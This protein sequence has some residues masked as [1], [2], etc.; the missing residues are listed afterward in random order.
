MRNSQKFLVLAVSSIAA[1]GS[2]GYIMIGNYAVP[3]WERAYRG[4][5]GEAGEA[6]RGRVGLR[7]C[8]VGARRGLITSNRNQNVCVRRGVQA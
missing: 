6:G 1:T 4:E 3:G 7:G 2:S 5:A 8:R